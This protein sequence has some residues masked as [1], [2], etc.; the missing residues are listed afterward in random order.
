MNTLYVIVCIVVL[1]PAVIGF[2]RGQKKT[3]ILVH[4]F[5]FILFLYE[6][7]NFGRVILQ[8]HELEANIESAHN[9]AG[10]VVLEEDGHHVF[11]IIFDEFSLVQ[12]L[13]SGEF[14]VNVV[15]NLAKFS[16]TSTWYPHARTLHSHRPNKPFQLCFWERKMS[17]ISSSNF[18]TTSIPKIIFLPW[19]ERWRSL[20]SDIICP[21]VWLF[22]KS[23]R[24]VGFFLRQDLPTLSH[25][26]GIFGIEPSPGCYAT[27]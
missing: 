4:Q 8:A 9:R 27:P 20:S 19:P 5:F 6:V 23:L 22:R 11:W 7:L 26:S 24:G 15:P 2:L 17:L 14:D 13:E 1:A 10:Q 18:Y 3:V 12:S 25:W 16:Q 21:I